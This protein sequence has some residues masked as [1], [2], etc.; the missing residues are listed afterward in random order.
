M[1]DIGESHHHDVDILSFA[2]LVNGTGHKRNSG[3]LLGFES[4]IGT[5]GTYSPD[6]GKK[7]K[8]DII[9]GERLKS[10]GV[11]P[12]DKAKTGDSDSNFVHLT[13]PDTVA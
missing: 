2:K 7:G 11:D 13:S 4:G 9:I 8:L 12:P 6:L 1:I 5:G 10:Q 3:L